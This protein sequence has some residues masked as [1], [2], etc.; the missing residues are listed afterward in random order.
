M[1][2]YQFTFVE[3][4]NPDFNEKDHIVFADSL[5]SAIEKFEK[6]HSIDAPA[7]LDLPSYE[8][9]MEIHFKDSVGYVKY[10]VTW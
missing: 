1:K 10:I 6:K 3:A 7:Y 9:F 2:R 4:D 5:L 8:T